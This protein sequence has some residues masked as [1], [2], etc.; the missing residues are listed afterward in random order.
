MTIAATIV[1]GIVLSLT[2]NSHSYNY[3]S[4]VLFGY[5][6]LVEDVEEKLWAMQLVT[7]SVVP[8]RWDHTRTPP[9]KAEMASTTIVKVKISNGSGK[10][11]TG[12]PGDEKKDTEREELLERVWT[13]VIPIWETKGEPIPGGHG[14]VKD[15][16]AHVGAF[17]DDTNKV[18][19]RYAKTAAVEKT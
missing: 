6:S 10:I 18:N 7:N 3:R 4:A 12:G 9:D 15:V 17:R 2:P 1:D 19:E 16:P 14:R 5:G 8:G 11:R 13:G